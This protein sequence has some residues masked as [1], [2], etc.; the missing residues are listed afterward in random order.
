[1][2]GQVDPRL[3]FFTNVSP[4]PSLEFSTYRSLPLYL[5]LRLLSVP[6]ALPLARSSLYSV[7]LSLPLSLPL[8]LSLSLSLSLYRA[9]FFALA[10]MYLRLPN[11]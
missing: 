1:M 6:L 2:R 11:R 4:S 10:L 7:S 9:F 3:S 5:S 8:S